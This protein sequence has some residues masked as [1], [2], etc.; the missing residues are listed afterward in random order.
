MQILV[1]ASS[2]H[3]ACDK[4]MADH[5]TEEMNFDVQSALGQPT[6]VATI[7][8]LQRKVVKHVTDLAGVEAAV[9]VRQRAEESARKGREVLD[10]LGEAAAQKAKDQVEA[11]LEP[12]ANVRGGLS[13]GGR[14][15]D[16]VPEGKL[17]VWKVVFSV[18]EKSIMKDK[19]V[20][21]P[22][23]PLEALEKARGRGT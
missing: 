1:E 15:V 4:L 20:A 19:A 21:G 16:A 13:G 3:G 23:K 7:Q 22:R 12:V 5:K 9:G 2:L 11:V 10:V 6:Q 8:L 17:G 18:A 14:W